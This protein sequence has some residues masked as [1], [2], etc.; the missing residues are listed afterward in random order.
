MQ[1]L[2]LRGC[3]KL[4]IIRAAFKNGPGARLGQIAMEL[5]DRRGNIGGAGS[6]KAPLE[7]ANTDCIDLRIVPLD[8]ADR[9]L[10]QFDG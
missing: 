1:P 6:G 8:P 7:I 4:S 3:R 10:R 9:V 5:Q 2:L